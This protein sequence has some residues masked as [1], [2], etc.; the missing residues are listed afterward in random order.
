MKMNTNFLKNSNFLL[1]IWLLNICSSM[2]FN[3]NM[4][5]VSMQCLAEYLTT[6]TLGRSYI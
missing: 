4:K 6:G 1:L 2:K 3:F 5:P